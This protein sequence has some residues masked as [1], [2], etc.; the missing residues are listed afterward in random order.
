MVWTV[1]PEWKDQDAYIIG[2]G[3]SLRDFD[4]SLLKGRNTI[5]CNDAFRLGEDICKVCI[6][7]D[8]S[9][10]HKMKWDLEKFQNPIYTVTP[11]LM[12]LNIKFLRQ[13]KRERHGI[14]G[15]D[16]LG[17]N[18]STGGAALNLAINY[19]AKRVF[20]L[21]VDLREINN[22]THWH[23]HRLCT[24]REQIFA[25]FIKGFQAIQEQLALYN[26]EVVHVIDGE[27]RLPFFRK[28]G[29]AEFIDYLPP[30]KPKPSQRIM[31]HAI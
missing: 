21:G 24:T 10:F 25:R 30:I 14:H 19:G 1:T 28:C 13:M 5:G 12:R 18:Y 20:L 31:E 3:A 7:G 27:S 8:A 16:S 2:G 17:W 29:M 4:F 9:W 23:D 26:V 22:K 11:S 15:G 6:F